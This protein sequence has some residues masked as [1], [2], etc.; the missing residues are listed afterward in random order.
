[1]ILALTQRCIFSPPGAALFKYHSHVYTAYL[2]LGSPA[3][4]P[5]APSHLSD[6]MSKLRDK[7]SGKPTT[8]NVSLRANEPLTLDLPMNENDVYLIRVEPKR[9]ESRDF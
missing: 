7:C 9:V 1:M 5:N 6:D 3:G 8:R 2:E 4:L